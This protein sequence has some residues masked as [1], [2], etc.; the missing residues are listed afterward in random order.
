VAVSKAARGPGSSTLARFLRLM[1]LQEPGPKGAWF[2]SFGDN[3]VEYRGTTKASLAT[4]DIYVTS[5][6]T[7]PYLRKPF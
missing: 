6:A 7:C 4:L 1:H 5:A 2:F 3:P